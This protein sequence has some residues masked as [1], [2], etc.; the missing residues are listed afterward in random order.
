MENFKIPATP[1]RL[2]RLAVGLAM[3]YGDS[4][5]LTLVPIVELSQNGT[6]SAS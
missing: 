3:D 5:N 4:G 2:P 1:S 6:L